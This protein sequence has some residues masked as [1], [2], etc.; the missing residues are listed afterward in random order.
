MEI[1]ARSNTLES[2]RRRTIA[3]LQHQ[4]EERDLPHAEYERRIELA[5][6]A[7]SPNELRPLLTDLVAAS[8]DPSELAPVS[9][10]ALR[11]VDDGHDSDFVF[12]LMSGSTRAGCWDPPETIHAVAVM[13][14]VELDFRDARLLE[15]ETEVQALAVMGGIKVIVP[16]DVH[17]AVGG[18][19]IFGSFSHVRHRASHDDAP[20]I[21]IGGLA[22]MGGVEVVVRDADDDEE[23]DE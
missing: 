4:H 2:F 9:R 20:R 13:G 11:A 22:V 7:S 15:G 14:G 12:A 6:Q 19:G 18:L 5:R 16:S 3:E 1:D 17:V 23:E 21:R 10:G 8:G